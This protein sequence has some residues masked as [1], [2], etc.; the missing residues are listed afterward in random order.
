[1]KYACGL[2]KDYSQLQEPGKLAIIKTALEANFTLDSLKKVVNRVAFS[3]SNIAGNTVDALF[4]TALTLD[5][6]GNFIK[7]SKPDNVSDEAFDS[8]NQIIAELQDWA[9]DGDYFFF[10]GDA[11]VF[12]KTAMQNGVVGAMDIFAFNRKTK[13]FHIIDIKTSKDF[14]DFSESKLYQY[15]AQQSI[16]RNL[17]Y[18]MMGELPSR[19]SLLPIQ[20]DIGL[21]GYINSAKKAGENLNKE[22]IDKLKA[23][24]KK[25]NKARKTEIDNQIANIKKAIAVD[26]AY[27]DD[28]EA[29]VPL[30]KPTDV[31]V[32][33]QSPVTEEG[34]SFDPFLTEEVKEQF[35][36]SATAAK[37][38]ELAQK[39]REA[40]DINEANAARME[41][42]M[43]VVN[44]PVAGPIVDEMLK[45]EYDAKKKALNNEV[46]SSNLSKGMYLISEN[47]IFDEGGNI[48]VVDKVYKKGNADMVTVK[49][50]GLKKAKQ[51]SMPV[52][53]ANK[54]F[55]KA[56]AEEAQESIKVS[57]EAKAAAK[58]SQQNQKEVNAKTTVAKNNEGTGLSGIAAKLKNYTQK[59][60]KSGCD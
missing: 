55:D 14:E 5:Q 17:V 27:I 8:I 36:D 49:S 54:L 3:E 16:Y 23:E 22:R 52:S 59:N 38:E 13:E 12:D 7:P 9:K 25:A 19:L 4:R 34:G 6:D 57:N 53:E 11:L 20:L 41:A 48:V 60:P 46:S 40:K 29:G 45:D 58:K 44:E 2:Q 10:V 47:P 21:D 43:L 24:K 15:S 37:I 31:P 18:N 30:V 50:I 33:L 51:K 1:M 56:T 35:K 42:L 32:E 28:V 39:I 26:I